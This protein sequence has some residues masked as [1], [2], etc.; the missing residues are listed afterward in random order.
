MSS[1][2]AISTTASVELAP[3]APA[4]RPSPTAPNERRYVKYVL[5]G[6]LKLYRATISPLYGEVCRYY[7]SC[8]AYAV[9]AVSVHGA[10][11]GTWLTVRRLGRC[12]PWASGGLDP[13]PPHRRAQQPPPVA[14]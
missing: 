5:I 4:G 6:L 14:T 2:V 3:S 13:V 7:P 9:E 1:S 12:H 8:S 10:L 11:R